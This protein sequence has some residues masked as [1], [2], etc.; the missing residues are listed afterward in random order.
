M[1]FTVKVQA[2]DTLNSISNRYGFRNYKDAGITSVKSGN[3]DKIG[4]GESISL[5]NYDPNKVKTSGAGTPSVISSKDNAKQVEDNTNFIKDRLGINQNTDAKQS[6]SNNTG[7]TTIDNKSTQ[8]GTDNTKKKDTTVTNTSTVDTA[9]TKAQA[10]IKIKQDNAKVQMQSNKDSF[11]SSIE[12]RLTLNNSSY[13]VQLQ[14]I[15]RIWDKRLK[16]QERLNSL[17]DNRIR[18]YGV[19]GSAIYQPTQ[20]TGAITQSEQDSAD[21]I[22]ELESLRQQ[23]LSQAKLAYEK[24]N[25]IILADKR[26]EISKLEQ[27]MTEQY[28]KIAKDGNTQYKLLVQAE[29]EKKAQD[30]IARDKLIAEIVAKVSI[31]KDK[32]TNMTPEEID[33]VVTQLQSKYNL[34]YADAYN[35]IMDGIQADLK[36]SKT[37]AEIDR[38]NAQVKTETSKQYKNYKDKTSVDKPTTKQMKADIPTSFASDTE[39]EKLR[40]EFTKKYGTTGAKYWN[41]IFEQNNDGIKTI[42]YP[43]SGGAS[44]SETLTSPDGTKQVSVSDLSKAQIKEAKDAGWK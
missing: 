42:N 40:Q 7:N 8:Q 37:Q 9:Y 32:Y 6:D 11:I 26:D 34:G 16:V 35:A 27:N 43:I 44:G 15:N 28:S 30:K 25:S 18:A 33:A 24:G 23:A 12:N 41:S 10:D 3:F 19:A 14:D 22:S 21:K 39:A 38:I 20:Y 29:K 36:R 17:R 4:V 31:Q 1:S 13:S 5:Q 2:G